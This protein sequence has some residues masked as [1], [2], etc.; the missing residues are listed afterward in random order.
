MMKSNLIAL[1]ERGE[2]V[3]RLLLTLA[4][5]RAM[6]L[7]NPKERV[8]TPALPFSRG[9][10]FPQF[11]TALFGDKN[12]KVILGSKP[13]NLSSKVKLSEAFANARVRFTHFVRLGGDGGLTTSA[14]CAAYIRKVGQ[15]RVDLLVP[16]LVNAEGPICPG[17]MTVLMIQVKRRKKPC[18]PKDTNYTAEALHVFD[19]SDA[20]DALM[21]DAKLQDRPYC[22]LLMEL[23]APM[24]RELRKEA[25][26]PS[27]SSSSSSDTSSPEPQNSGDGEPTAAASPDAGVHVLKS[28]K[29]TRPTRAPPPPLPHPRYNLKA[30]GCSHTVYGGVIDA[31]PHSGWGKA[32]Y[33]QLLAKKT[34]FDEHPR[35]SLLSLVWRMKPQWVSN[36]VNNSYHWLKVKV[37][38][39]PEPSLDEAG[40]GVQPMSYK[41]K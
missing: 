23:M 19:D 13:D 14:L 17:N 38:E 36:A 15:E 3:A 24:P 16:V 30:Y 10:G 11:I 25:A 40:H 32:K 26:R 18:K 27:S 29:A 9:C 7:A 33:N 12:A 41:E 28:K 34:F 20:G 6:L 39:E 1:G 22:T 31:D 21:P 8:S 2:L 37:Q 35:K 5:D 4:Y